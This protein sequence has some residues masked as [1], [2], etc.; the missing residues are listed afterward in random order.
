MPFFGKLEDIYY[1]VYVLSFSFKFYQFVVLCAKFYYN[2][3][4]IDC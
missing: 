3:N 1:I 4:V 2:L